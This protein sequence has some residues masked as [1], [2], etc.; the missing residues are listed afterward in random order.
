MEGKILER[1][2]EEKR[3]VQTYRVNKTA[4]CFEREAFGACI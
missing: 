3:R 2:F 1:Y 4:Q